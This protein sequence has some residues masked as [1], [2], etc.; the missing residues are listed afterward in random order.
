[1]AYIRVGYVITPLVLLHRKRGGDEPVFIGERSW[2][3][4]TIRINY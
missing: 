4:D 2:P 3:S 1:M